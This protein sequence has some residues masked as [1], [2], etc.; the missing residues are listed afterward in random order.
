VRQHLE[1]AE[2][3][4]DGAVAALFIRRLGADV[5]RGPGAAERNP[6]RVEA[7]VLRARRGR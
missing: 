6:P 4:H 7:P 3:K 1:E 2:G 5:L